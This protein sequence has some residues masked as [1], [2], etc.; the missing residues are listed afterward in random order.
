MTNTIKTYLEDDSGNAIRPATDWSVVENAPD[1]ASQI[2]DVKNGLTG[3]SGTWTD[4]GLQMLSG[5][6]IDSGNGLK[7]KFIHI[8]AYK[9]L[10]IAGA[11]N[12]PAIKA[13]QTIDVLSVPVPDWWETNNN[14]A[15]MVS[16]ALVPLNEDLAM[17]WFHFH[18]GKLTCNN[19]WGSKDYAGG[20][21]EVY[22]QVTC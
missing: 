5:T 16:N 2:Q 21:F 14:Y 22:F 6:T 4:S 17:G 7:Y 3:D 8:G 15:E 20:W 11:V 10:M 18:D 13:H 12:L 19:S 1:F 9:T